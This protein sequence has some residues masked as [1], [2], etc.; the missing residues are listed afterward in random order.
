MPIDYQLTL[1]EQWKIH[2]VFHIDLLTPYRETEFHG[3]NYNQPPSDLMGEVEQYEVEHVLDERMYG[4]WK[5]KQYLVKWKGDPDSDNQWLDAKDMG[6]A[7]ELIAEFHNSNCKH[8]S[9]IKRAFE[10][11]LN[12]YTLSTL[13]S[14]LVSKHMSDASTLAKPPFRPE[15]NM[16]PLPVPPCMTTSDASSNQLHV[17]N[18]MPT[19]TTQKDASGCPLHR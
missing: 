8:S 1:P 6:N 15:E 11:V 12:L 4:H 13:P 16:D 5:K 9:H 14:I 19:T 10:C 3:P 17:Q 7:H 2:D 18:A